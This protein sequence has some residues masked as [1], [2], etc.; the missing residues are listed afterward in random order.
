MIPIRDYLKETR[1]VHGRI[2]F[3]VGIVL[4]LVIVLVAR[5]AYLQIYQQLIEKKRTQNKVV[6]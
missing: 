3:L 6:I 1:V 5:L 2:I 4:C